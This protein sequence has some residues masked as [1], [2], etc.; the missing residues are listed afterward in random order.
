MGT[1]YR[2]FKV[3]FTNYYVL[4]WKPHAVTPIHGHD[5]QECW[6]RVLK[7]QLWEDRY[8][9]TPA[10]GTYQVTHA[11]K[12]HEWSHINDAL[13]THS[14]RNGGETPAYSLHQYSLPKYPSIPPL[15]L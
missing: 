4:R 1:P 9:K 7:G 14:I 2:K 3:P 5:N 12:P 6:F 8:L 11:L 15:K 13:G 10:Q